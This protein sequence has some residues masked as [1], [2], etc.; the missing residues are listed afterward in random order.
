M[1]N[2]GNLIKKLANSNDF[3][4]TPLICTVISVDKSART[5]EAE[6]IDGSAPL[7]GVSLQA[8]QES[9]SGLV[10]YPVPGSYVVI[11]FVAFGSAGIV[12]LTDEIES[13]DINISDMSFSINK[14][15]IVLNGGLLG[16]LVEIAE[17]TKHLNN[18]ENDINSL[19]ALLSGWTPVAEDGGAAL[20]TSIT[21]WCSNTIKLTNQS[22]YEN[23][24]VTQ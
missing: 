13:V 7:T 24:N 3:E 12:L 18:I 22:D 4:T 9:T 8:N 6:P 21:S 23:K 20:K 16:G 2:I 14:D 10:V 5:I 1:N 15:G 19:K 17:L 11:G